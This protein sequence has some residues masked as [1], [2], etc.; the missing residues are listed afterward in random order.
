MLLREVTKNLEAVLWDRP[1][2]DN[3]M[4]LYATPQPQGEPVGHLYRDHHGAMQFQWTSISGEGLVD[5]T[6]LYAAPQPQ[7]S[8]DDV[9]LI[10]E[11]LS[12]TLMDGTWHRPKVSEIESAWQRIRADYER[13]GV[14]K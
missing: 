6:K 3:Q 2:G 10:S 4:A 12:F 5:G 8:A 11:V 9:G 14:V 7:A 1:H 13:M